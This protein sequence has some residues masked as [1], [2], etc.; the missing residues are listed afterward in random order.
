MVFLEKVNL[1][2]PRL[3]GTNLMTRYGLPEGSCVIPNRALYMD[4]ETWV[5][6]VKV[7]A[8][9]IRKIKVINVTYVFPILFSIHLTLHLC[10]SKLSS[11]DV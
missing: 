5:K 11:D 8:T 2:H 10:T 9:G 6:V 4:D 1:V 3:R 7:V